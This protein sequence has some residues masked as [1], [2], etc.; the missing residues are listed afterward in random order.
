MDGNVDICR[1]EG[2]DENGSAASLCT[3][4]GQR[5][6]RMPRLLRYSLFAHNASLKILNKKG[7]MDVFRDIYWT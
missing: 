5:E 7:K 1:G 4:F 3:N 2:R 6:T